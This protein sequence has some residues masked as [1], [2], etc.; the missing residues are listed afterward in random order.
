[1]QQ[2]QRYHAQKNWQRPWPKW[3][4]TGEV[5]GISA[6]VEGKVQHP[7]TTKLPKKK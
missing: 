4:E 5:Q 1:M 2:M 6:A 7:Q 3:D